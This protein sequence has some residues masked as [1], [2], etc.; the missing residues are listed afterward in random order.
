MTPRVVWSS[1]RSFHV[2][3]AQ[4][5]G[6]E[7][8]ERITRAAE[9]LQSAALEEVIDLTPASTTIA[10]LL[11]PLARNPDEIAARALEIVGKCDERSQE[12]QPKRIV[13]IPVCYDADLAPDLD[14]VAAGAGL[15]IEATV[16]LHTSNLYTVRFLGFA[17][18]FAYIA[19]LPKA[20]HGP[21]LASPRDRVRAGSIG[22][23]G[24]RTCI[25]PQ[26]TPGGWRLIG[27][28]PMRTF[29]TNR[30]PVSLLQAGDQV[31]FLPIHRD[32]FES[33]TRSSNVSVRD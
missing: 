26:S 9:A 10:I 25:Y 12:M 30:T 13:T 8:G 15:S 1:E 11:D 2:V 7:D 32:E 33:I 17:P 5:N 28:T 22:I 19:G 23:A 6:D 3:L 16:S 31:R 20:L 14:A 4:G 29:D 21:R 27:A 18:G 24:T